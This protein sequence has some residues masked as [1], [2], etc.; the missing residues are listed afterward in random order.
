MKVRIVAALMGAALATTACGS[1]LTNDQLNAQARESFRISSVQ[2][3]AASPGTGAPTGA[4]MAVPSDPAAP[5]AAATVGSGGAS[6]AAGSGAVTSAVRSSSAASGAQ[7]GVPSNSSAAAPKS[8]A[9][10][11]PSASAAAPGSGGAN[12]AVGTPTVP[13]SPAPSAGASK[14]TIALG[15]FGTQTGPIG[16]ILLPVPQGA[17]A[18]A[19]DINARG[20]LA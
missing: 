17:R 6:T 3:N 18:W 11:N 20:G 12:P 1:T 14:S 15:S 5:A 8:A 2:S 13:G 19:A 16:R 10:T 4:V 7:P 9:G